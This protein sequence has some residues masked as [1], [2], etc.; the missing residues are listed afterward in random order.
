MPNGLLYRVA[1]DSQAGGWNAPCRTD[2]SFCYVPIPEQAPGGR[3]AVFD[4]GYDEFS[5]FVTALGG[6]WPLN[7]SGP[8]HLDPDFA[9]LTY[10]D[11]GNR[12]QRLR[13]FM[14]PGSFLVFWAG[15]RWLDGKHAGAIVCSIIGFFRVSHVLGASDVG[16]LD[17]HRNAHTRRANAH[18]KETVAFADPRESGRLRC[19]LPIGAYRAG[20]QRVDEDLLGEWGN[21]R[22]KS[23]ELLKD[24]YIQ[25]SG[26]PPIFNDPDRFLRWFRGQNPEFVHANNISY[27]I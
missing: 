16:V 2:G 19:H 20:A 22:R 25:Q 5:P 9:N 6:S 18:S 24:G 27:G 26:S 23:G 15:L 1:V 10:G 12:A 17:A 8:C 13:D 4:H 3:G 14:V 21:L 7:L 11:R